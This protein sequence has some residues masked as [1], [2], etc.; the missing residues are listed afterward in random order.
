ME[1]QCK[2]HLRAELAQ[3]RAAAAA[4]EPD[5]GA[6]LMRVWPLGRAPGAV[7]AGYVRFRSEIDPAP[8]M[9]CLAEAGASLCLP[10]TPAD[11]E[12]GLLFRRYALGD[13][14]EKSRFGIWEPPSSAPLV[15]PYIILTPLLGFDRRGHRLGYGQGHYDRTLAALRAAG[16]LR[17]LGLAFADQ[18]IPAVPNDPHDQR[19]D[20]ILTPAQA[21]MIAL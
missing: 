17:A 9:A 12:G 1:Q 3:R 21:H 15:R 5:A 11:G 2:A 10:V 6:S 20:G 4:A 8:L 16:P 19:L 7:V 14:L 13:R 18:E